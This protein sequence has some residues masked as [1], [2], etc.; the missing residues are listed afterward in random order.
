M[1][2]RK[3]KTKVILENAIECA[4]LAVE[5]YNKPRTNYRVEGYITNMI[6]AWTKLFQ[7]HFHYTIGD[8]FYYKNKSGRYELIEGEK[9]AWELKTCITKYGQ[10][11]LSQKA[12]LDFFIKLRNKIEHRH[13]E[14]DEIGITIFGECQSLL[15]NFESKL[16]DFFGEE[17]ALNESLS[18]AL[19]FSRIR[20]SGQSIASKTL[21]SKEVKDLREFIDRYKN[22]LPNDVFDS[23]EY[24]I[25]LIQVPKISNTNR[26]DLAIEFVNWNNLSEEDR[27]NYEKITT[28]IKDKVVHKEVLNPGKLKPGEVIRLVNDEIELS[29]KINHFD[30]KC[31]YYAFSIRPTAQ[32]EGQNDPFDC[33]TNF[34][35]YDEVHDDYVFQEAWVKFLVENI[36]L[37]KLTK[38]VWKGSYDKKQ[39]LNLEDF[40]I[41]NQ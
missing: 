36:S 12:N 35:H 10:L 40:Q 30:L 23:Q 14:K 15:Y 13:I 38:T 7:A 11:S 4:L 16:I 3:G 5:I 29:K 25:K 9:K 20:T 21:L 41:N 8:K 32:D 19:Q 22:A 2:L 17:Y 28:I 34:C 1:Q 27:F 6:M 33:N 24:S 26:S 37:E 39:K 18:F 31:L